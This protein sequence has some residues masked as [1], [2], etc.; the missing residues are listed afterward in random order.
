MSTFA[1][2]LQDNER[3]PEQFGLIVLETDET[4][5]RDMRRLLPDSIDLFVSRVPFAT[6]V[7]PKTLQAMDAHIAASAKLFP[8]AARFA[9]TA[10]GC[11]SG[12]AQ[13][14]P[15]RVT[16]L[17]RD[18]CAT[19]TVTDPV[20]ALVAACEALGVSNLAFLSPYVEDVSARLRHVL[21]GQGIGTSVVGTFDEPD[22]SN[23]ARIEPASTLQAAIDLAADSDADAVFM[24]CTNLQT[25]DIITPLET[26]LGRPVLSSNLVL[27]WHMLR[28]AGLEANPSAPGRLWQAEH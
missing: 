16:K 26:E 18:G 9:V 15:T 8:R 25:L 7:S 17:V 12:T 23:V 21:S 27:A 19:E 14:G 22:D 6:D 28:L 4:I 3:R 1:Y 2:E 13:I 24:S 20:S 5:E 11:T 10:Y